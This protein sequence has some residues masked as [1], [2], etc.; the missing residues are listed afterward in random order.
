M[1]VQG[2]AS[3]QGKKTNQTVQI[4]HLKIV[5]LRNGEMQ[6]WCKKEK[7]AKVILGVGTRGRSLL[8]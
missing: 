3:L 8:H 5:A 7:N 2:L 1:G 6:H 4:L